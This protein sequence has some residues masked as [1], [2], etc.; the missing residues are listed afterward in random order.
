MVGYRPKY[1][2]VKKLTMVGSD[3]VCRLEMPVLRD[4]VEETHQTKQIID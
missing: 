2:Q 3:H 1:N 4:V